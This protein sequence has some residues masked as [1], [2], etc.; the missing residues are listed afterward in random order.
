M[1]LLATA[2][3]ANP[4]PPSF[5]L[6]QE[7]LE[8][9][10]A[11]LERCTLH[12]INHV[13][14]KHYQWPPVLG[15]L[16][17]PPLFNLLLRRWSLRRAAMVIDGVMEGSLKIF[18]RQQA[19]RELQV[20][21][22][23]DNHEGVLKDFKYLYRDPGLDSENEVFKCSELSREWSSSNQQPSL[24]NAELHVLSHR[25]GLV[26]GLPDLRLVGRHFM[27]K[28][29]PRRRCRLCMFSGPKGCAA[30]DSRISLACKHCKVSLHLECFALH[31]ADVS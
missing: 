26:K 14:M 4:Q 8:A 17:R 1:L 5:G 15:G 25:R 29:E 23:N 21:K 3:I 24:F 11:L 9:T 27:T 2:G 19:S 20:R 30:Y 12:L 18:L 6:E 7:W 28:T 22:D 13:I 10:M 31:R 16:E